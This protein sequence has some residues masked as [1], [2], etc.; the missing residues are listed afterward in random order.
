[1]DYN[2]TS[3]YS[4]KV[5]GYLQ[6]DMAAEW[7]NASSEYEI[8]HRLSKGIRHA[9]L[10]IA[11]FLG[12]STKKLFFTAGATESINSVLSPT[13]LKNHG[14]ER[15][16][17]SPLEHHATLGCCKRLEESSID[18][19]YI[20]N[21]GFG[22]IDLEDLENLCQKYPNS[23][24][25]LVFVNNET[26]V[27]SPVKDIITIAHA[28]DCLVHLD[29]VQALGKC[30]FGLDDLD[31]DFASFSGHKIGSLKGVG[32]LYIKSLDNFKPFLLGGGQERNFR[33]G[34]YNFPAIHSLRLAIEDTDPGKNDEIKTKRDFFEKEFL[35]WDPSF[36]ING[37]GAPRV[38]NTSNIYL[39]GRS[40][41]EIMLQLSARNVYVST[42][43][44]C[45]ARNINPSHVITAM[46]GDPQIAASSLR[47]SLGSGTSD[48][49]MSL[50]IGHLK[51]ILA[52]CF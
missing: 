46:G 30:P 13:N 39:G 22:N 44:A 47:V 9:R 17:T 3:P 12:C 26:G 6:G 1:M 49:E 40:S 52:N 35:S 31:V 33:A 38:S 27:I 21:D 2:S 50:L 16:V 11:D 8:G 14:I 5:L 45:N 10:R 28:F 18:I 41:M 42:G 15:V 43:S 48:S 37:A 20:R 29:G 7:G 19:S 24:V 36:E 32:L 23:M 4:R 51:E 25:S 34:T